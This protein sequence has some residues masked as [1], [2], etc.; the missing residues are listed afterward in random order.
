MESAFWQ[1]DGMPPPFTLL[2]K[3]HKD[4]REDGTKPARP[5]CLARDCPNSNMSTLVNLI[6]NKI[7][8]R[9]RVSQL[10]EDVQRYQRC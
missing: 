9:V 2:L 5:L 7:S 10:R 4:S 1:E 6:S 3:D 8:D